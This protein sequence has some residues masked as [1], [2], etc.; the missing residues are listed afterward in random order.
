MLEIKREAKVRLT[1][2]V[3]GG[4]C[5]KAG[6]HVTE[7]NFRYCHQ[8]GKSVDDMKDTLIEMVKYVSEQRLLMLA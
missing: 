7:F 1:R 3:R 8:Y 2:Q 5:V 4:K 6:G